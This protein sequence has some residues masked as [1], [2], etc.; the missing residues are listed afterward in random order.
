MFIIK[1]INKKKN[2]KIS[3][4]IIR[5]SSLNSLK[6]EMIMMLM[7]NVVLRRRRER[8]RGLGVVFFF[9]ILYQEEVKEVSSKAHGHMTGVVEVNGTDNFEITIQR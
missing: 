9:W 5:C 8:E 4:I 7:A 1:F 6:K 2:K 3:N